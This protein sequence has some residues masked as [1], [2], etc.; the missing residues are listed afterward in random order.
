MICIYLPPNLVRHDTLHAWLP[1]VNNHPTHPAG[2]NLW[3]KFHQ[4]LSGSPGHNYHFSDTFHTKHKI[5][6]VDRL[7]TSIK[8]F[9]HNMTIKVL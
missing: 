1:K 7:S 6:K 8:C 5:K 3:Q 9:S 2:M 4:I